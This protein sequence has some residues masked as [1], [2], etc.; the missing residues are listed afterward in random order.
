MSNFAPKAPS[1]SARIDRPVAREAKQAWK[2]IDLAIKRQPRVC[3]E[4]SSHCC[5]QIVEVHSWEA[6]EISR[7]VIEDMDQATKRVVTVQL[8]AWHDWFD[9]AAR[10][11]TMANPLTFAEVRVLS[12]MAA[13]QRIKCP[14]LVNS[15]CSIYPVRPTVCRIHLVSD[16]PER[17][18]AD[19]LRESDLSRAP[20]FERFASP[21]RFDLAKR[22]FYYRPLPYIM[23]EGLDV[24]TQSRP[25]V[26]FLW[27]VVSASRR[28]GQY[29][30]Y[31]KL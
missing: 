2:E 31:D 3:R 13:A 1:G 15:R 10:P 24:R 17:C 26:G 29:A 21:K 8:Q 27:D 12:Q 19:P 5:H 4:G 20:L 22:H 11:S 7:Y 14:Y 16:S 30:Q 23:I 28:Q 9:A 6:E 18:E 25:M